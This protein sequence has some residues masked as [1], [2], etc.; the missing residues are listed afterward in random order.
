VRKTAATAVAG[1]TKAKKVT[2]TSKDQKI[3]ID[4]EKA[5]A[6]TKKARRNLKKLETDTKITLKRQEAKKN[7]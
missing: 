6:P 7:K 2:G 3:F 5:K 1:K 4:L